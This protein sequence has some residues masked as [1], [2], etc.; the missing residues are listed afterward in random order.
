VIAIQTRVFNATS[1]TVPPGLLVPGKTYNA[2][3]TAIKTDEDQN[4]PFR[5]GL[6][7]I[8]VD[9]MTNTFTP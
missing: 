3:I 5:N 4:R 9:A 1:F 7:L 2:S 6:P 8:Q